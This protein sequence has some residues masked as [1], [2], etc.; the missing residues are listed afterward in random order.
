MHLDGGIA[1]DG[2]VE[3]MSTHGCVQDKNVALV[4]GKQ[5]GADAMRRKP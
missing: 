1:G 3:D 2:V 5:Y 4:R